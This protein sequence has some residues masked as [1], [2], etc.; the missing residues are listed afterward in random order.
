M[1]D[2][3]WVVVDVPDGDSEGGSVIRESADCLC[4]VAL[5][6]TSWVKWHKL[7]PSRQMKVGKTRV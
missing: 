1:D 5:S 4:R 2:E 6:Q 7:V 3:D